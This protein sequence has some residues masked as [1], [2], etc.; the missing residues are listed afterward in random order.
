MRYCCDTGD[1]PFCFANSDRL[2]HLA[3][4]PISDA[5]ATCRIAL[6]RADRPSR[7]SAADAE[8]EDEWGGE[9]YSDDD[10]GWSSVARGGVE[11]ARA[12]GRNPPSSGKKK[13]VGRW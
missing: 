10:D 3:L 9:E 13:A 4:L 7:L 8:D 1:F 5:A 2:Q 6:A 11:A 12:C